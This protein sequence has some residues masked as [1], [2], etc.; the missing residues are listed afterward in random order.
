MKITVEHLKKMFPR[1]KNEL[2]IA[3]VDELNNCFKKLGI[4][5][6]LAYAHYFAQFRAE[7][8]YRSFEE[9]FNYT[10]KGL[11]KQ[12]KNFRNNRSLA[13]KYGRK[14]G[15]PA[16]QIMIG[17]IAYGGRKELGNGSIESGDGYKYRGRGLI[18][19][20]G[21]YNYT[22]VTKTY[23]SF[24]NENINFV[25]NPDLILQ[26]KY[27]VR[28][29][30]A[31][32]INKNCHSHIKIVDNKRK[33]IE[34]YRKAFD[35][36]TDVINKKTDSREKRWKYFKEN[37]TKIFQCEVGNKV[38]EKN[39]TQTDNRNIN[40]QAKIKEE[41]R[42]LANDTDDK[43]GVFVFSGQ[44][45][46]EVWD[47]EE[48][49]KDRY[50]SSK[51]PNLVFV[52]PEEAVIQRL[53]IKF[54]NPDMYNQDYVKYLET[55]TAKKV[56]PENKEDINL[57]LKMYDGVTKD[58]EGVGNIIRQ[59]GFDLLRGRGEVS[60]T[61]K[62]Q[63]II[64]Y[65]WSY[66]IPNK[67]KIES[68]EYVLSQ[69][70]AKYVKYPD[71]KSLNKETVNNRYI[72]RIEGVYENQKDSMKAEKIEK[73]DLS[74][75][76]DKYMK[77]IKDIDEI[78]IVVAKKNSL[79]YS[80]MKCENL[81]RELG[82]NDSE[83]NKF[84]S[85]DENGIRRYPLT[86]RLIDNIAI[87][88]LSVQTGFKGEKE[89]KYFDNHKYK[90]S[91]IVRNYL[92]W[93]I[94]VQKGIDVPSKG[95]NGLFSRLE[96][97]GKEIRVTT[98]LENWIA[99]KSAIKIKNIRKISNL[100][101]EV[102]E[103]YSNKPDFEKDKAIVHKLFKDSKEM[104]DYCANID[105]MDIY[106]FYKSFYGLQNMINP[107]D[108]LFVNDKCIL[109]C[110]LGEDISRL[111]IKGESVTLKGG[112][113]ANIQDTAI[114]PFKKCRAIG[115]CKPKLLGNWEKNTDV[116]VRKQPALLDISTI[117]CLYGGIISIDDAGQREIKTAVSNMGK[118]REAARDADCV[119]KLLL[120]VASDI[121]KNFM[122]TQIKQKAQKFS[123]WKKYIKNTE[124]KLKPY[125]VQNIRTMLGMD[126]NDE[127]K[128]REY[129]N[130]LKTNSQK[131]EIAK[132][133]TSSLKEK[134][135]RGKIFSTFKEAHKR[136]KQLSN[137]GL[138]TKGII[139]KYGIALCD[140]EKKNFY[141]A[142]ILPVIVYGYLMKTANLTMNLTETQ[143]IEAELNS[144]I[145]TRGFKM[146]NSLSGLKVSERIVKIDEKKIVKIKSSDIR[147][148]S[149][150]GAQLY[151][152]LKRIPNEWDILNGIRKNVKSLAICPFSILEWNT[153]HRENKY[154]DIPMVNE[155]DNTSNSK[156]LKSESAVK[157]DVSSNKKSLK[158]QSPK[159]GTSE[160]KETL[161][162][163]Q[164]NCP[165]VGVKGYYT[166]NVTRIEENSRG[167]LSSF[168][169]TDPVG[170]N[171]EGFDGFILERE[172]PDE[173]KSGKKRRI[174]TGTHKLRWHMR[175]E[176][177]NK[178]GKI[179][180]GSYMAIG[181]YNHTE[182]KNGLLHKKLKKNVLIHEER[183]I[184]IHPVG[185]SYFLEGCLA[186]TK[187]FKREK[188]YYTCDY[189]L[190]MDF[191]LELKDY[192]SKIEGSKPKHWREIKKFYLKIENK[193]KK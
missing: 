147:M 2:F 67:S 40:N 149:N 34:K 184:L 84:Y 52:N 90:D 79:E 152:D 24:F 13:E 173:I 186:P 136:T 143:Y 14:K 43:T 121:N 150:I 137:P 92:L 131:M 38:V 139:K 132:R 193:L 56:L 138:D 69:Y 145:N 182:N 144:D 81:I 71:R 111:L 135:L 86:V 16:N 158:N 32:M 109:K 126:K 6:C 141:S 157:D 7:T 72:N 177:K 156:P 99:S 65:I 103:E 85:T 15:R 192:I 30:F 170:K 133:E 112:K 104:R 180:R 19:V 140:Y 91:N 76:Y 142:K 185:A 183:W 168:S 74:K 17:N 11:L 10:E 175:P 26:P 107:N 54:E 63:D 27:A 96:K 101:D 29:S 102:Y 80:K 130:L 164:D 4:D 58:N 3:T 165:H 48:Y 124:D 20:T 117:K 50:E 110:T 116:E 35:K 98:L 53:Q 45:F 166:L 57:I 39:D 146:D 41:N 155:N 36:M 161:S 94:K 68:L 118:S 55:K 172:G 33:G 151:S 191:L 66:P 42:S 120:N 77:G 21:K 28:A 83:N 100:I 181:V 18:Q 49:K 106:S 148:W 178:N 88:F 105:S 12:F 93:Y 123:Q 122:Q 174:V 25:S 46:E 22:K 61:L 64:Y 190:S 188:G 1:G 125:I 134:E 8:D 113:Q 5:N 44:K 159:S 115:I 23:N 108:E 129:E 171:I 127:S 78:V 163:C 162:D 179:T 60:E 167:T 97:L 169:L 70:S 187:N 176:K 31:D 51:A 62:I 128:K 154:I 59:H 189:N 95:E 160:N 73:N 87:E 75:A 153:N 114:S 9:S 37:F 82:E 119:Y 47:N 89:E